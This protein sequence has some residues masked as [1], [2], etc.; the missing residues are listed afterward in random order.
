MAAMRA[1]ASFHTGGA[2]QTHIP[3]ASSEAHTDEIGSHIFD[4]FVGFCWLDAFTIFS[5]QDSLV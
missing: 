2:R 4:D 5:N 1:S 3:T